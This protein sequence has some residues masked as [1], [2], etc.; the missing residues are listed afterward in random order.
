MANQSFVFD[1]VRFLVFL[2]VFAIAACTN[3]DSAVY[4]NPDKPNQPLEPG[5]LS[6]LKT[7]VSAIKRLDEQRVQADST[8]EGS[9]KAADLGKPKGKP[10]E[11]AQKIESLREESLQLV[12]TGA[13]R[14]A[15]DKQKQRASESSASVQAPDWRVLRFAGSSQ[16]INLSSKSILAADIKP[17]AGRAFA[18]GFLLVDEYLSPALEK[19]L[20]A[21]GIKVIGPHGDALKVRFPTTSKDLSQIASI[22]S[23]TWLGFAEPQNKIDSNLKRAIK[24][25]GSELA[26]VPIILHLFE[27]EAQA[28]LKSSRINEYLTVGQY[29]SDIQA[30]TAVLPADQVDA[31]AAEDF[32]LYLELDS[33]GE[34]GHDQSMAV[35]GVDYIRSGGP[36]T[37]FTGSSTILGILD[38]GFM[39]GSA[40][41]TMHN[42][43]NKWGCGRNFTNDA[44]NVWN[45]QNAHGTHVLGTIVGTGV[46]DRRNRG[47]ATGVGGSGSTRIRA[48]K[49]WNSNGASTTS[50]WMRNGMDYLDD[51]TSC[52]SGRPHVVN[53]SGGVRGT[54]QTGTDSRSRKLDAKVWD[55][56]QLY[57]VCSGNSGSGPQTIWAPGVAK[58]A[59]TVGNVLD[60]SFQSV[61][62]IRASSSRGPTGDNRMKPNLVA[63]GT[64]VTST[65]AGTASSYNNQIGCSMATP[66]VAGIAATVMQHY[67][68]MRNR[69][70]L[71][72]AHLMA[73]SILHDNTT[74]PRNN[75]SG[76]RNTYGLG[77]VST[78]AAHWARNNTNGWSTHWAWRT[79]T[80]RQWGFRDI[81]IPA[82]TDRLVVVMTWD[83]P[84]ASAGASSAVN[85]DLDLWID[86]G[87]DCTPDSKGQCGEWASQSYDDNVEYL[88]V[89]NPSAG[90][91]RLK[92]IN[93]DAPSSGLPAAIAAT[94]VRGDPTPSMSLTAEA[95]NTTPS[96][97]SILEVTTT[98]RSPSYITSGVHIDNTNTSAGLAF[99]EVRTVREDGV[100]MTFSSDNFSLG[101]IVQG[102]TRQAVWRYRVNSSV[103]QRIKFRAWSE[104]GGTRTQTVT[105]N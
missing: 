86:R 41:A 28:Y 54:G 94:V 38:T 71:L 62:D 83:E 61:G 60:N 84:A 102:D 88:I 37:N 24:R 18:Y 103:Q 85:N 11:G 78:Y 8:S 42:D 65:L 68:D 26:E 95:N 12:N 30:Y 76:G 100:S 13:V 22:G 20:G 47:V 19:E 27:P 105:I 31:L 43:L 17:I 51:N 55:H 50:A 82:G 32:V 34:A 99:Q 53:V 33:P 49:I 58:N 25:H 16:H 81:Q 56:K 15:R 92:I 29:D 45:D 104:N 87:A 59:L 4:D 39:V 101:N 44:A 70:Y 9:A 93:W 91:Y 77:R 72:R 10:P 66:H 1:S 3:P 67:P 14:L 57:V 36:G 80:N 52:S 79:I 63:S 7:T 35:L 89:N 97:G 21:A 6:T 64:T 74:T 2:S 5:A 75:S 40:A 48:G 73:T 96:V 23:V 90:T 69:P 46:G 98:V